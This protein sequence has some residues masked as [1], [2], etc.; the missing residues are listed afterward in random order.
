MKK[1]IATLLTLIL[2]GTGVYL[3]SCR[4]RD[5]R[6]WWK[7][8]PDGKTYLVIEESDGSS[9]NNPCTLD[10]KLWL[11]ANGQAG[12][13]EPG[14]HEL[15]CPMNVGFSVKPGVEYHFDYWGP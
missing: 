14:I 10:G 2:L 11:Y 6:G 1:T 15:R 7:N 5:L 9:A 8:S 13:I 4:N 3:Y 12:E